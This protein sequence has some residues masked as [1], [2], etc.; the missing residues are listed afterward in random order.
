[1]VV[2]KSSPVLAKEGPL[3]FKKEMQILSMFQA[4]PMMIPRNHPGVKD[5]LEVKVVVKPRNWQRHVHLGDQF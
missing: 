1:M 4:A 5:L 2:R 3:V